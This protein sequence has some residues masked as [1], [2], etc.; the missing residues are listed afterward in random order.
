[1]STGAFSGLTF[2]HCYLEQSGSINFANSNGTYF[3]DNVIEHAVRNL[4]STLFYTT[5]FSMFINNYCLNVQKLDAPAAGSQNVM[6]GNVGVGRAG[7]AVFAGG[8]F[9]Q[10]L[11]CSFLDYQHCSKKICCNHPHFLESEKLFQ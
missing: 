11:C 8:I 9:E 2:I 1:M 10:W 6:I 4:G 5:G 7:A 3:I